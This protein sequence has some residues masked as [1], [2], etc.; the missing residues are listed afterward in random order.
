MRVVLLRPAI[1]DYRRPALEAL[2][3][4]LDGGLT[5]LAGEADFA[6]TSRTGPACAAICSSSRTTTWP[7]AACSGSAA[8]GG[9]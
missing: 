5:V 6:P 1:G 7:A 2:N 4:R 8:A 3:E 9:R